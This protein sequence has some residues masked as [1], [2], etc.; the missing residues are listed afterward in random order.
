MQ[1][2]WFMFML[3]R[4]NDALDHL[5]QCLNVSGLLNH[6]VGQLLLK[7]FD[8]KIAADSSVGWMQQTV[9][10]KTYLKLSPHSSSPYEYLT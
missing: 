9:A 10:G 2:C 7:K 1:V 8:E 4:D 6:L 3:F 5:D